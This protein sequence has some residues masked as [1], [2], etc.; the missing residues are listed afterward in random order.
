MP[1][2]GNCGRGCAR[3]RARSAFWKPRQPPPEYAL[4]NPFSPAD[5]RR[6]EPAPPHMSRFIYMTKS[7]LT[8]RFLTSF[9][10]LFLVT[11]LVARAKDPQQAG[12]VPDRVCK[13][14]E[15]LFQ[16]YYPKV[17]TTNQQANGL[18]FE[19]EVT[20]YDFPSTDP[21]HKQEAP[22]QIGPQQGGI[23]CGIYLSTGKYSGQRLFPILRGQPV[24]SALVDKKFYK[25]L[26]MVPYSAKND[27]YLWVSLSYPPDASQDFLKEFRDIL[28]DYANDVE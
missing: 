2:P 9:M 24:P 13:K 21:G 12:P 17:A 22:K 23:L 1:A 16:K 7:R 25:E 10:C 28:Q 19:Y 4:D 8:E 11:A 27:A 18:H 3:G 6:H 5:T 14:M 20:N 26:L 15:I